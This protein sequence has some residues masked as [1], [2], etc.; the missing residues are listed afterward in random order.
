MKNEKTF[1]NSTKIV[2][3]KKSLCEK[4]FYYYDFCYI[5]TIGVIDECRNFGLGTRLL[6]EVIY[7]IKQTRKKC[8]AIYLH[9]IEYNTVAI[10]FYLKNEFIECNNLRNYYY[11]NNKYYHAKALCK[12][13]SN[14][15]EN[16]NV[17][18]FISNLDE[19]DSSPNCLYI[20][21]NGIA[22]FFSNIFSCFKNKKEFG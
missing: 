12:V 14:D 15:I 8:L 7:T 13:F 19:T 1:Y 20:F 10:R 4:I 21:I 17:K 2:I 3:K 6:N 11:I 18:E 22:S 5:M 9:V 16:I